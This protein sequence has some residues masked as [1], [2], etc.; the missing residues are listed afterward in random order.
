M[1]PSSSLPIFVV[2]KQEQKQEQGLSK[3]ATISIAVT[4][5]ILGIA[6]LLLAIWLFLKRKWAR[7]ASVAPLFVLGHK[8][9]LL[10]EE[11]AVVVQIPEEAHN[12][13]RDNEYAEGKKTENES[14]ENFKLVC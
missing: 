7:K 5:S 4:P 3:A 14:R 10:E 11:D 9:S 1:A 6:L 8:D 12:V 2:Q 13:W